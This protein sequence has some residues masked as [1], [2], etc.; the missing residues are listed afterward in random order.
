MGVSGYVH[1]ARDTSSMHSCCLPVELQ[2]EVDTIPLIGDSEW[3]SSEDF[4]EQLQH[5]QLR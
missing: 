3:T 5:V 2:L 1:V 4:Q